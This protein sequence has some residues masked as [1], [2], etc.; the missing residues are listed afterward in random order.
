M[1]ILLTSTFILSLLFVSL[2]L[3]YSEKLGLQDIPNARSAH[4]SIIPRSAGL[5][6][7]SAVLLSMLIFNFEHMIEYGYIYLSILAIML[8]GLY[9][10]KFEISYRLKFVALLFIGAYIAYNGLLINSLGTYFGYVLDIPIWIAAP[11]T[12]FAIIGFTNA[13]NLMDGFDG[14]A[15]GLSSIMMLTFFMI[16]YVHDD[17]LIMT[18]SSTFIVAIVAFLFFNWHPAKIFMGDS[19]SLTLGFVIS[20][21]SIL[22]LE[23]MTP[24]AVLFVVALPLMDTF[25]VM[26]RRIQRGQSPFKADKNHI[27]HFM[28][29]TKANV[30]FSV[31]LLLYI[32]MAFSIMGYQMRAENEIL[33]LMLFGLLM[34]IFLNIFDQRFKY[35]A[36][37]KK[38]RLK[39]IKKSDLMKKTTLNRNS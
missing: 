28:Y 27:H 19:G 37:K 39:F 33:S 13:L 34:Y 12:L 20:I 21:L 32:Q 25:I 29:K 5:G 23:Y 15:G 16:G 36:P 4:K 38:E 22:S 17:S 10:D 14:L 30:K 7:T 26:K 6:L 24:T 1:E 3:K 9:D 8:V 11:F 2:L 31:K 35:R 18:L